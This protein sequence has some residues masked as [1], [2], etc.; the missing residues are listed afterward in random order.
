MKI[1]NRPFHFV[2]QL[3]IGGLFNWTVPSGNGSVTV[4]VTATDQAGN[5]A[6]SSGATFNIDNTAPTMVSP[7]V[8]NGPAATVTN[9]EVIN[10]GL[11]TAYTRVTLSL[12]WD[13]SPEN[14]DILTVSVNGSDQIFDEAGNPMDSGQSLDY[15]F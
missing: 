14:N 13:S 1:G 2:S 9:V 15:T 10:Q 3:L 5:S 6:T 8:L 11:L 7:L 4:Q 12:S